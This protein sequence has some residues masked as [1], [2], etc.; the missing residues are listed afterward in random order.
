MVVCFKTPLQRMEP[1]LVVGPEMD[2]AP[3]GGVGSVLAFLASWS[4]CWALG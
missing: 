2:L 1:S 4:H 3:A